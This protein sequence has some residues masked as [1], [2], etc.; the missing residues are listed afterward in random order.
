MVQLWNLEPE[1]QL[2]ND[3]RNTPVLSG[4][5]TQELRGVTMDK[6]GSSRKHIKAHKL[7]RTF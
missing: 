2:E 3:C 1:A 5:Q 7:M 6:V 4:W